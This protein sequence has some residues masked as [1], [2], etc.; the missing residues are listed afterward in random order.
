MML[1][2]VLIIILDHTIYITF[3]PGE[4]SVTII[5]GI[6]EDNLLEGDEFFTLTI[7]PLPPSTGITVSNPGV[8][9]VTILDTDSKYL[10]IG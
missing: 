7:V 5:I 2:V 4:I 6:N 8:A 9:N 1:Q 10:M 3:D